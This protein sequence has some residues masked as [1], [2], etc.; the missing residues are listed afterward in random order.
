MKKKEGY[1]KLQTNSATI[2]TT[3]TSILLP[4]LT[5][6]PLAAELLPSKSKIGESSPGVNRLYEMI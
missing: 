2:V 3:V 1:P 5:L 6:T 4:P